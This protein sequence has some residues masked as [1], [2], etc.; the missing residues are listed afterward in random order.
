MAQAATYRNWI[1]LLLYAV[2]IPAA[3]LHPAVSLALIL[4]AA[5]L[6]FIPNAVKRHDDET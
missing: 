5:L 2:A 3:F 1:A 4:V 6:Y